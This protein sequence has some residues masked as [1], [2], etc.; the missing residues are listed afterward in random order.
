MSSKE[1]R[2]R[3][4]ARDRDALLGTLWTVTVMLVIAVTLVTL[5]HAWFDWVVT[6]WEPK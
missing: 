6:T 3:E 4:R 2:E 5:A 1:Q